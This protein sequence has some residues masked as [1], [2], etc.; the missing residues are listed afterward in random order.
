MVD[1]ARSTDRPIF[2][3][4]ERSPKPLPHSPRSISLPTLLAALILASIA[5]LAAA[6]VAISVWYKQLARETQ[7]AGLLYTSRSISAAVDNEIEKYTS[8][9]ET[10]VRSPAL[11]ANDLP[12]F[13]AEA[14]RFFNNPEEGWLMLASAAGQQ[15]INTSHP[16]N[17]PLPRRTE[18]GMRQQR[19]ANE[20]NKPVVSSVRRS[21]ARK[22]WAAIIDIPVKLPNGGNYAL[23]V[24][25]PAANFAA[26]LSPP[27]R[28]SEWVAG[29]MDQEGRFVARIPGGEAM[30]GE[31]ASPGWRAAARQEG[32]A[33]IIT[34]EGDEVVNANANATLADWTV[35]VAAPE[36]QLEAAARPIVI[37][38]IGAACFAIVSLYRTRLHHLPLPPSVAGRTAARG[39]FGPQRP[40][41]RLSLA[42]Y[43][44]R[45]A[46]ARPA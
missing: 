12:A 42:R 15:L 36:R 43:G 16:L 22:V 5:P 7:E 19:R 10:L 4:S 9:A 2:R 37:W 18:T 44:I 40:C 8:L 46:L 26:F 6:G 32:V 31:S 11:A 35:G 27:D 23:A 1:N 29:V 28:R 17:A 30:V 24:A 45:T 38:A 13:E 41:A 34:R 20:T 33:R 39:G 21:G 25:L 14:R 3:P